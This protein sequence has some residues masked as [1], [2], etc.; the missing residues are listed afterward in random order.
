MANILLALMRI[1]RND[2]VSDLSSFLT[3]SSTH[4]SSK[5]VGFLQEFGGYE[6]K[7]EGV[8]GV[9]VVVPLLSTD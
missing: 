9:A 2:L 3:V 1:S 4:E 5:R 8:S 6:H 7:T